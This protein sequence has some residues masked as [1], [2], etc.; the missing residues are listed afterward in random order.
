MP[1][2]EA[3]AI[4]SKEDIV[5][6]SKIGNLTGCFHASFFDHWID[7]SEKN[8][9]AF[10][11]FWWVGVQT[12]RK[13]KHANRDEDNYTTFGG[14][15]NFIPFFIEQIKELQKNSDIPIVI[16]G[17]DTKRKR[18]YERYLTKKL[19]FKVT[20]FTNTGYDISLKVLMWK[21]N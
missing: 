14:G 11:G 12:Y 15:V 17:T 7:F 16:W 20:H 9:I 4:E 2:V 3:R 19:G 21:P 18:V 6:K 10:D 1:D 5:K 8:A 13:R